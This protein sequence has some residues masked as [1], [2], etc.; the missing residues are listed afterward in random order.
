MAF[1]R[2]ICLLVSATMGVVGPVDGLG[3][4]AL[5]APCCGLGLVNCRST[6]VTSHG[7]GEGAVC[8]D[9]SVVGR[10][11]GGIEVRKFTEGTV[12]WL[13]P[14]T[15]CSSLIGCSSNVSDGTFDGRFL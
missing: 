13:Y 3:V 12:T 7:R 9:E 8:V 14:K 10:L 2:E 6:S 4:F 1:P 5:V 11:R 15:G